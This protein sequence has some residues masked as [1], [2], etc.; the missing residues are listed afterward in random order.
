MLQQQM[1]IFGNDLTSTRCLATPSP[2]PRP[3]AQLS[4]NRASASRLHPGLHEKVLCG[5][6]LCSTGSGLGRAPPTQTEKPGQEPWTFRRLWLHR[7]SRGMQRYTEVARHAGV[8]TVRPPCVPSLGSLPAR[9][10]Q[11]V[12]NPTLAACSVH[13]PIGH[14]HRA[15]GPGL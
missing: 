12:G 6:V 4:R 1:L 2:A 15:T 11:V 3:P 8:A 9:G 10:T 13:R 5:L 14:G 7:G